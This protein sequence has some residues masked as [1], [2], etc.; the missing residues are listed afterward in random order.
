MELYHIHLLGNHDRLYKEKSEFVIDRNKF[1]NRLYNRIYNMTANVDTDRYSRIMIIINTLLRSNGFQ[2]FEE[3]VN[4]GEIISFISNQG[5]EQEEL[6]NIL[7]D[8]KKIALD[9]GINLREMAMEEY[10]KN[11]CDNL[12]SRLHSLFACTEE[13]VNFWMNHIRDNSSDIYRIDVYDE[14]FVS[15]EVL[16]PSEKLSYGDKIDASYKYFHPTKKDLNGVTD[17]YLVQGK[18]KI[19]EKV[20]SIRM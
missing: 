3:K 2:P 5:C 7:E 1:N 18:V 6:F 4:L 8:A 11:N 12:P 19:I 16:L 13:G 14:P 20:G 9:E 15:N 10:R 17:E